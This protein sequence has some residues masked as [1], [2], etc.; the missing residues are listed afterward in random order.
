MSYQVYM[1]NLFHFMKVNLYLGLFAEVIALALANQQRD[2]VLEMIVYIHFLL[3]VSILNFIFKKFALF[4][5]F[6]LSFDSHWKC[7]AKMYTVYRPPTEIL[8]VEKKALSLR[9]LH[10]IH[11]SRLASG[12]KIVYSV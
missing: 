12:G 8:A 7:T 5:V 6:V 3:N 10:K 9:C 1:F 11:I 4:P 2:S